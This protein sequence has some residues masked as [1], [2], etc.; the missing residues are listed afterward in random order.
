MARK[1]DP[2]MSAAHVGATLPD[3]T[4]LSLGWF[5]GEPEGS[6]RAPVERLLDV[7]QSH[8]TR[9]ADTLE[10]YRQLAESTPD[11]AVALLLR[12]VLEDEERHHDLLKR[13]A[14]SLRDAMH[15]SHSPEALP[16]GAGPRR[17]ATEGLVADM[18]RF[19]QEEREGTRQLREMARR[20]RLDDDG[21]WSLLLETMA[22]DSEKHER[23]LRFVL[24]RMQSRA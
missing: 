9:E 14:A 5:P 20:S 15:W 11:P 3:A 2:P 8:V 10:A 4:L 17:G 19:I 22:A 18:R 12:L 16:S 1:S 21:L 6:G 7:F 13:M 24:K 23:I